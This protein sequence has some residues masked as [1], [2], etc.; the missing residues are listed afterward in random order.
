MLFKL[1]KMHFLSVL[2][3]PMTMS[4]INAAEALLSGLPLT[5]KHIG[6]MTVKVAIPESAQGESIGDLVATLLGQM[7]N[8]K[9]TCKRREAERRCKVVWRWKL[10]GILSILLQQQMLGSVNELIDP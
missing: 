10:D 4:G 6:D 2:D 9:L 1:N 5:L 7:V 3:I 8:F